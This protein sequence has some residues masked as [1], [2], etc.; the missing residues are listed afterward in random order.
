ML[1]QRSHNPE[2]KRP[3]S[4]SATEQK[5]SATKSMAGFVNERNFLIKCEAVGVAPAYSSKMVPGA[6]YNEN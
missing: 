5:R 2:M 1:D 3:E 6:K 4:C